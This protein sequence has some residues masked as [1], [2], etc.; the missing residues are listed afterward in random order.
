LFVSIIIRCLEWNVSQP[1]RLPYSAI[2]RQLPDKATA[3]LPY[4]ALIAKGLG[5]LRGIIGLFDWH[6]LSNRT[7][8]STGRD[9]MRW[10]E[11]IRLRSAA[12]SKDA[13]EKLLSRISTL[14][15]AT[16]LIQIRSYFHVD[17]DG[18]ASIHL[19]WESPRCDRH[20]SAIAHHIADALK[21]LGLVDVSVWTER[22]GA[23][24]E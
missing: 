17:V 4:S 23:K 15:R 24:D 10:L 3:N 12:K 13:L 20:G 8:N 16:G 14:D 22:E 1:H 18:D 2:L 11:V 9:N 21:E 7:G 19:F 5:D 6:G